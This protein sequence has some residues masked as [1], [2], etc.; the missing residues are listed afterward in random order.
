MPGKRRSVFTF[1]NL[2]LGLCGLAVVLFAIGFAMRERV[3]DKP[4]LRIAGAS[5]IFNYR[6]SDAYYGFTAEVEKPVR[7]FSTIEADFEDPAGGPPF[8][9][10][11]TLGPR[12]TRYGLRSPSLQGIDKNKPYRVTVRLIQNGDGAV[13]F[14]RTFTVTSD[15]SQAVLPPA[16]LTVGPGYAR[17]P[18]LPNGW[19]SP[20]AGHLL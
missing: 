18:D 8:H 6:V 17:N 20:E 11:T 5:F 12:T 16:P 3:A 4:Y 13:L 10:A 19:T 14:S 1:R 7:N 9:V 2:A 15:L